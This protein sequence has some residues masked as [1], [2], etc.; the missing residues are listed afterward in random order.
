MGHVFFLFKMGHFD[1]ESYHVN[2]DQWKCHDDPFHST[3]TK[4]AHFCASLS[5]R[6][7]D[8]PYYGMAHLEGEN[9]W[10]ILASVWMSKHVTSLSCSF[11]AISAPSYDVTTHKWHLFDPT[12]TSL[13]V[14]D[15]II[16]KFL[17]GFYDAGIIHPKG[18][19]C[20]LQ[21][22]AKNEINDKVPILSISLPDRIIDESK[23]HHITATNYAIVKSSYVSKL[24]H[25]NVCSIAPRRA[26]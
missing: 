21:L 13:R 20:P 15:V 6:P 12:M 19:F 9:R 14:H 22:L 25:K 2:S 1:A 18:K 8:S 23:S 10:A 16:I 3:K 5:I 4:M 17:D 24:S 7:H 11:W 26:I